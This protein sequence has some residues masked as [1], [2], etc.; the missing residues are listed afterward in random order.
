MP[1]WG[2]SMWYGRC[3]LGGGGAGSVGSLSSSGVESAGGGC[4]GLGVR[5]GVG[6]FGG[7]AGLELTSSLSLP[8]S[9]VGVLG[10]GCG[11]GDGRVTV[12]VCYWV[13]VVSGV[14]RGCDVAAA[15]S[16]SVDESQIA[17]S[18]ADRR[19]LTNILVVGVV[20]Q[21]RPGNLPKHFEVGALK[22][23]LRNVL[24]AAKAASVGRGVPPRLA[25]RAEP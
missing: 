12:C 14:R 21:P 22:M 16:S 9:G 15:P 1:G 23:R 5:G 17:C 2:R 13:R 6:V 4:G 8:S 7:C 24:M 3:T 10:G 25:L 11:G 19:G 20:S 18:A